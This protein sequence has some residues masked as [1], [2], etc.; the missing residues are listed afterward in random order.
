VPEV[1]V[2]D[3]FVMKRAEGPPPTIASGVHH[4]GSFTSASH[5]VGEIAIAWKEPATE[6][7]TRNTT[8]AICFNRSQQREPM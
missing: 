5:S 4:P 2:Q 8:P 7:N 6:R 1:I 3:F